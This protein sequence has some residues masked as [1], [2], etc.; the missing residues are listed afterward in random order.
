MNTG[1]VIAVLAVLFIVDLLAAAV[2]ISMAASLRR[3]GDERRQMIVQKACASTLLVALVYLVLAGLLGILCALVL[4]EEFQGINP[5]TTLAVLALVYLI[6]VARYK[7]K[8]GDVR[9]K[10]HP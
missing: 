4:R 9:E 6:Q 5:I 3:R 10:R 8:Y 1:A 2:I 7:K